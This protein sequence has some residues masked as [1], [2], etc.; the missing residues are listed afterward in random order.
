MSAPSA[1]A[2]LRLLSTPALVRRGALAPQRPYL[3]QRADVRHA[4]RW[5]THELLRVADRVVTLR[6]GRRGSEP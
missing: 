3:A 2:D 4:A 5:P 6:E 1:A